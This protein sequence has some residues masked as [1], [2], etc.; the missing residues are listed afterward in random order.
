MNRPKKDVPAAVDPPSGSG[1]KRMS[2]HS[3]LDRRVSRR[4]FTIALGAI[5][6]LAFVLRGIVCLQ[7]C[8]VPLVANPDVVTDMA[9]YRRIAGE[10]AAGHWPTHFYYQPFYY[11]VFLPLVYMLFGTGPWGPA[12]AQLLLGTAAVWLTGWTGA[13]LFGRKA[14]LLAATLLALA[15]LPVFY[16]PF[17][18]IA[19][20][21]SFWMI[22]LL[23][24]A[25]RYWRRPS[26]IRCGMLGS[27]SAAAIL[28]RGNVLLLVP[29]IALLLLWRHRRQP[30]RLLVSLGIYL[31]LT[32]ALQLPFSIANWRHYGRWTGPSSAQ[33]A[34]LAL[35]NTP[36]SPA[37][38][39]DYPAAF[40]DWMAR[41]DR[42]GPE[43]V[44]VSKQALAWLLAHPL[45]FAELKGRM[46]LLFWYRLEIPNNVSLA[47]E[48]R[49]CPLLR[50]PQPLLLNFSLIG[51]GA[52]MGM[53]FAFRRY[54]PPRLLAYYFVGMYC[55][56]TILFYILARF[57]LP[58][59]PVLCL[60]AG[61]MPV[62]LG[63]RWRAT[64]GSEQKRRLGL[65][66][67]LSTLACGF[68][69]LDGYA[70]YGRTLESPV[71]RRLRPDG[72]RVF[73]QRRTLIYD[74]GPRILGGMVFL[75]IGEREL[76]ITK[77]F[78]LPDPA[79][80]RGKLTLAIPVMM[81]PGTRFEGQL[82]VDGKRLGLDR[83]TVA[84]G[85][86]FQRLVFSLD[87]IPKDQKNLTAELAIRTHAGELAVAVDRHRWYGRS[88]IRQGEK[89]LPL[90]AEAAFELEWKQ[91]EPK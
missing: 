31:V 71:A 63:A 22:L 43:R 87:P 72:T 69:V 77:T 6:L 13:H 10:I 88:D 24:L 57:R 4:T 28:T 42:S 49:Y 3:L 60:F 17:L 85:P 9:T 67:A 74:H 37:G 76:H 84:D 36:E 20:L 81:T 8:R 82:V 68:L 35:G 66:V 83:M 52:L 38:G 2:L 29:G 41:A 40:H 53:I 39:L 59:V 55:A 44:P 51:F 89:T 33:D 70:W 34:V 86:P 91:A 62:E 27:V 23:Y 73:T 1:E 15:R 16:T 11:A 61:A 47:K 19:T 75:P 46:L 80:R 64:V 65:T 50:L 30:R 18:L 90:R 5:C 32:F 25:V 58:L 78:L 56:G 79:T 48:G 21:Q 14:G 12:L 7:L 54:S 26:P 45:Q